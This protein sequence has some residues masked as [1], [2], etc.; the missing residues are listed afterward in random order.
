MLD[1]IDHQTGD[2][3]LAVCVVRI[4]FPVST[5]QGWSRSGNLEESLNHPSAA[6]IAHQQVA[7]GIDVWL[8]V[9]SHLPRIVAKAYLAADKPDIER[10]AW[11]AARGAC[12]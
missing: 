9:M 11:D 2:V 12:Y 3:D 1:A 4:A 8:N 5:K 6:Q 10:I 7:F